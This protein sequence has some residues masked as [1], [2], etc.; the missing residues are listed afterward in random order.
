MAVWFNENYL[1]RQPVTVDFSAV[2]GS[3]TTKDVR[4]TVPDDWDL[5]WDT[6]RSDFKDV[7]LT[8]E[9]GVVLDFQRTAANFSNRELKLEIDDLDVA[10]DNII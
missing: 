10:D 4:I 9:E 1:Y 8:S 2:T 6:I 3:P 7:V 5:F